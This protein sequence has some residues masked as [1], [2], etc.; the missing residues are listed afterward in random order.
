MKTLK[1]SDEVHEKLTA[2]LGELTAQT[3]KMQTYQDAIESLLSNSV[4]MPGELLA[5][6]QNYVEENKQRG[7]TSKEEFVRD[8]VRFRLDWLKGEY[9][10]FEMPREKIEKMDAIMDAL[11]ITINARDYIR[12]AMDKALK[13]VFEEYERRKEE[14]LNAETVN[15][16][17]EHLKEIEEYWETV[18][19]RRT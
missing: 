5:E 14:G 19:R 11:G 7:Y 6:V 9:E 8:S 16:V 17:E 12:D 10:Y 2:L 1:I 4:I 18:R 3:R 15:I 13:S